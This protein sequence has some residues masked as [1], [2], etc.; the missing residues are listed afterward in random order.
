MFAGFPAHAHVDGMM[1]LAAFWTDAHDFISSC[2]VTHLVGCYFRVPLN[3]LIIRVKSRPPCPVVKTSFSTYLEVAPRT[4]AWIET[5][6]VCLI[7]ALIP[8]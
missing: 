8:R 2:S 1:I 5:Y 3:L 7:F 6:C 4:G